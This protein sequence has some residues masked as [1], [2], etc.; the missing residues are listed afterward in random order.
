MQSE[1][2]T[3]EIKLTSLTLK[4]FKGVRKF[5]LHPNGE[6]VDVFGDNEAGKTTLMD[7]FL[8]LLFGKDSAG[9]SDFDIKT[10]DK[11]NQPIHNIEHSV[12]GAFVVQ[13]ETITLKKTFLEK[14]TKKRGSRSAEFTGHTTKHHVNDVP[15]KPK[16]YQTEVDKIISEDV[17]RLLTDPRHFTSLHWSKQRESIINICG[18]ITDDEV[19]D[20]DAALADLR[21][22]LGKRT[23]DDHKKMV[24][25]RMKKIN[26][27]LK[28]IP[29]RIDELVNAMPEAEDVDLDHELN[30]VLQARILHDQE[31]TTLLN[32]DP[33]VKIQAE[34]AEKNAEKQKRQ[35]DHATSV[36]SQVQSL[37]SEKSAL[38]GQL[39]N[40]NKKKTDA[41]RVKADAEATKE[42][43]EASIAELR[44]EWQAKNAE[45][46]GD[47]SE[48]PTCGQ[49]L[50]ESQVALAIKKFNA[51]KAAALKKINQHGI[52]VKQEAEKAERA[53]EEAEKTIEEAETEI[54]TIQEQISKID[55]RI[56]E[57][58]TPADTSDLD[59]AIA[60][61][62]AKEQTSDTPDV[63][64]IDAKITDCNQKETDIRNR[65][66]AQNQRKAH[67]TRVQ[68]LTD[69]E[70]LLAAE[71]ERLESEIHLIERFI[72]A[73]VHLL[74]EKINNRF[75]IT[76]FKL[77]D[78]Q[79]NGGIQE[80]CVALYNGVPY[81]SMNN[82]ARVNVGLDIINVLSEHYGI[83]A[84]VW[85]D[86]AEAVTRYIDTDSQVIRLNVSPD[87]PELTINTQE[88]QCQK[89]RKAS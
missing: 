67:E 79:I 5:E 87:H 37:Q 72:I 30:N 43:A 16:E 6:N 27:E 47:N 36:A 54:K 7:A 64:A 73:K 20:S 82:A 57:A 31:K 66:A 53:I 35:L 65:I 85:I 10:L 69:R 8:W 40:A 89:T 19:L 4:N 26:D 3:V 56:A 61:L 50:P 52:A 51:D 14:W 83:H 9:R 46:P 76:R 74:E 41:T 81:N 38:N 11:N 63:S 68:E 86:N 60:E 78:Q 48:C 29:A 55:A 13:G 42:T 22:I 70:Q 15:A 88:E 25:E 2:Q 45:Q 21:R 59:A 18:D 62:Q 75:L 84:P 71:Y 77:F 23:T 24:H 44:G 34:I 49:N 33:R 32:T 28:E 58:D 39:Y 12:E 1:K 17:F 80:T